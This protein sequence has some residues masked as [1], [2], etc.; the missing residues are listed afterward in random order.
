MTDRE[1]PVESFSVARW[2]R[3]KRD[4]VR[5]DER[6]D[7]QAPGPAEVTRDTLPAAAPVAKPTTTDAIADV[8]PPL[9]PVD[10]LT[11]DSDFSVFMRPDVDPSL[12]RQALK[13]LLSDPRFNVMDGL[14]V[15]IDDYTKMEPITPEMLS[16][17]EHAK[18]VLFPPKTRVNAQGFVEDVPETIEETSARATEIEAPKSDAA[19]PE[20]RGAPPAALPN[21][22]PESSLDAGATADD[23]NAPAEP[24]SERAGLETRRAPKASST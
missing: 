19:L 21:T 22:P 15:Y 24:S 4:A 5:A 14:D 17:L 18:R 23:A 11:F 7:V 1:K 2:S 9:P 13:K 10:S 6:R 20:D 8:A 3:R 16:R 12:R